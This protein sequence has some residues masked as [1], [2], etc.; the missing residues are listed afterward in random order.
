MDADV[1]MERV[2]DIIGVG[3][4]G[5]VPIECFEAAKVQNDRFKAQVLEE[6]EGELDRKQIEKRW[7]FQDC[8][9]EQ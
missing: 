8:D 5:W 6:A 7:P 3:P 4:E 9:E 1:S 2:K